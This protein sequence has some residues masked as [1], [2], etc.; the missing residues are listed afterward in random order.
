MC[1][2]GPRAAEGS[3][4]AA[5]VRGLGTVRAP[6]GLQRLCSDCEGLEGCRAQGLLRAL[7]LQPL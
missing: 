1:N 4:A 2:G 5:T 7:G 6:G 3:R